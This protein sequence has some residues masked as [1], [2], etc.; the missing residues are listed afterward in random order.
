MND[1]FHICFFSVLN[2]SKNKKEWIVIVLRELDL[3]VWMSLMGFL[4]QKKEKKHILSTTI[5][6]SDYF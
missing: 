6:F 4:L 1:F 5:L 2:I 3:K